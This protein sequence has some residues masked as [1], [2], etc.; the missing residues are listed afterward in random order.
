MGAA[1]FLGLMAS[2]PAADPGPQPASGM[3]PATTN[4]PAVIDLGKF[5]KS[6]YGSKASTNRCSGRMVVDGVPLQIDGET[7]LFGLKGRG[8][9][10]MKGIRVERKFDEIHL[11]HTARWSEAQGQAIALLRLNYA[12]GTRRDIPLCYGVHVRDYQRLHS[13]EKETLTDPGSKIIWRGPGTAEYKATSRMFKSTL[14]NPFPDKVVSTLDFISTRQHA[15][16]VLHAV[17]VANRDPGRSATPPVPVGEPERRFDGAVHLRVVDAETSRAID[18]AFVDPNLNVEDSQVIVIG[19]PAS[20][21]TNGEAVVRY[22]ASATTVLNVSVSKEGWKS[23]NVSISLDAGPTNSLTV[24][25]VSAPM[26]TGLVRDPAGSPAPGLRVDLFPFMGRSELEITTDGKGAFRMSGDLSDYGNSDIPVYALVRDIKRNL[27]AMREVENGATNL[28][29]R[30]QPGLVIG[31][32]IEDVNGKPIAKGSAS[33]ILIVSR[34]GSSLDQPIQTDAQGRFE[35]AALPPGTDHR[36]YVN[37]SAKGFGSASKQVTASDS[38]TN[39]IELETFVLRVADR[40]MAGRVVDADDKPVTGASI[41]MFGD[42]QPQNSARTDSQG[43]F[44]FNEVCE[45][46]V[47]LSANF[48]SARASTHA[49]AGDTNVVVRL[50]ENSQTVDGSMRAIRL[51]G[52]VT[53]PAGVPVAGLA[54][55]IYPS[56]GSQEGTKTDTNGN[57]KITWIPA[58]FGSQTPMFCLLARDPERNLGACAELEDG[59]TNV[60]LRLQPG[61]SFSG[62]VQD[63]D[64]KA[65]SNATVRVVFWTGNSGEWLDPV[66]ADAQGRYVIGGWPP[67]R[68]YG[69][70]ATAKGHGTASIDIPVGDTQTNR[71][72]MQPLE[73]RRADRQLAG[74]V[75]NADEKPVSGAQVS[76]S[77]NGQPNESVQTDSKGCF[78]F[79]EVCEGSLRLFAFAPQG[80]SYANVKA[81]GGDTNVVITLGSRSSVSFASE[82]P[83]RI[84][85][86]GKPLPDLAPLGIAPDAVPAGKRVLVCLF[87][88]AQRPSRRCARLLAEQAGALREKGVE[89]LLIQAVAATPES[90]QE[91]KQSNPVPFPVG[92]IGENARSARWVSDAGSFP[93]LIL[94]DAERRVTAE[95]FAFDELD[96]RL[97]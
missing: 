54:L 22:P 75:V 20:T 74:R 89:I 83:A 25:M 92:N 81:E 21:S 86:K 55:K 49:E 17:T 71:I 13:E 51:H 33:V 40:R 10:D 76:L 36:F 18:G 63:V 50:G 12:D 28:D 64:G 67:D 87:D 78:V 97:K 16:Y 4:D 46:T 60:D 95:G 43:R 59:V 42:G 37:V 80:G 5:Y 39:R 68:H 6:K 30:L 35:I 26:I 57:F 31:G 23:K 79:K 84:S 90:M 91:W 38:E 34:R 9:S 58:N 96:A 44:A 66:K 15:N 56:A 3:I 61:L 19:D 70:N 14:T 72:E 65:L 52:T 7:T 2:A 1:L 85:L 27:V 88:A 69:L 41:T 82:Q 29:I 11:A 62:Q 77:G 53:D 93:Y 47:Q 48:E 45:G 73:L 32:K 94:T 8:S 24:E